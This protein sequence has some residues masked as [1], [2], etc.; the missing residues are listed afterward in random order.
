MKELKVSVIVMRWRDQ[1]INT[2]VLGDGNDCDRNVTLE[3][4]LTMLDDAT[5]EAVPTFRRSELKEAVAGAASKFWYLSQ[6]DQGRSVWIEREAWYM[7]C[8]G[9]LQ[10]EIV[11]RTVAI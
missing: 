9:D 4:P 10:V 11:H 7:P 3:Y 6:F 1:I 2:K 8:I 5:G